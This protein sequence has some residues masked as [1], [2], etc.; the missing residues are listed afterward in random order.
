MKK[1]ILGIILSI[2]ALSITASAAFYSVTGLS[3]L[4]AGASTEVLIMATALELSKLVIASFLYQYW[5]KINSLLKTYLTTALLL[6]IFITSIG[7]YGF[8]IGAYQKTE[9]EN[10]KFL[11]QVNFIEQRLD[12]FEKERDALN[13]TKFNLENDLN[14]LRDNLGN[15][16]FQYKDKESGQIITTISTKNRE[17]TQKEI[18]VVNKEREL[19][20]SRIFMLNDSVGKYELELISLKTENDNA[21]ELGPLMYIAEITNTPMNQVI[22]Y[23][24]LIIIF[25]FDP[26][27]ICLV[28]SANF[29]FSNTNKKEN[30]ITDNIKI[31]NNSVEP[32][33]D[34]TKQEPIE[35]NKQILKSEEKILPSQTIIKQEPI[36]TDKKILKR[37]ETLTP[38]PTPSVSMIYDGNK[39]KKFLRYKK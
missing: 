5:S 19:I 29:V 31:T 14:S 23:L 28:I 15:N 2:S 24:V 26:L 18:N 13:K 25:V 7:I 37:E 32:T 4:F 27:A 21:S 39:K 12:F 9:M 22:N 38:T 8:L 11:N 20:N 34:I 1:I 17:A 30:E 3:K 35:T 10:N 6:L 16:T 33:V 36:E